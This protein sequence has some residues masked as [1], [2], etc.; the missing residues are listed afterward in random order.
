MRGQ[1]IAFSFHAFFSKKFAC[2]VPSLTHPSISQEAAVVAEVEAEEEPE[3][4]PGG[5]PHGLEAA[6]ALVLETQRNFCQ[7]GVWCR[8]RKMGHHEYGMLSSMI[9]WRLSQG[10]GNQF[11]HFFMLSLAGGSPSAGDSAAD[12]EGAE[13]RHHLRLG[14]VLRPIGGPVRRGAGQGCGGAGG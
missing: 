6:N 8:P 7:F 2:L 9:S 12:G 1:S 10:T 14:R 13:G 3:A 5:E 11:M 4:L